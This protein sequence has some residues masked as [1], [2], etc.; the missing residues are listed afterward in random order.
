MKKEKLLSLWGFTV[1][2]ALT[3]VLY[4]TFLIAYL[5]EG[6]AAIINVNHCGEGLLEFVILPIII[7]TAFLGYICFLEGVKNE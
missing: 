4:V 6:Q 1:S 3:S 2:L 7:L 5:S